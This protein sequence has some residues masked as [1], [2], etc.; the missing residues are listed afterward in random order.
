MAPPP[1]TSIVFDYRTQVIDNCEFFVGRD[2]IVTV[3]TVKE[4]TG[5]FKAYA[6]RCNDVAR[7]ALVS[8]DSFDTVQKAI[9]SLHMKSAEAVH[10]YITTNGFSMPPDLKG[11]K[12]DSDADDDAASLASSGQTASSTAAL[13]EWDSSDEEAM[14]AEG[15]ATFNGGRPRPSAR[16][17]RKPTAHG[18]KP[19]DLGDLENESDE[20][21]WMQPMRLRHGSP[22]RSASSA[23]HPPPGPP[24]WPGGPPPPRAPVMS[25]HPQHAHMQHHPPPIQF[26]GVSHPGHHYPQGG[27]AV[28]PLSH[29]SLNTN[30]LPL[31][32]PG[33]LRF[34]VPQSTSPPTAGRGPVHCRSMASLP[35]P[36][37]AAPAAA[38]SPPAPGPHANNTQHKSIAT[39]AFPHPLDS[40]RVYDVRLTIRWGHHGEQRIIESC[41]ASVRA[42]QD[43]ALAYVAAHPDSFDQQPPPNPN[44]NPNNQQHV[45]A[46]FWNEIGAVADRGAACLRASVRRA[47]FGGPD[48]KE[49]S[50]DM[51]AYRGDDLTK[52]FNVLGAG[53]IPRFEIEVE[54]V[55]FEAQGGGIGKGVGGHPGQG[56]GQGQRMMS[57]GEYPSARQ[58]AFL[59]Q[60]R[61]GG[62]GK[63]G[64][65]EKGEM[66]EM[67][68]R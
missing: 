68:A 33:T 52:L 50:Y 37:A 49:G 65:G 3:V 25:M 62:G 39:Y 21:Q 67:G 45:T 59:R 31:H 44:P 48:D 53:S 16:K 20:E 46:R 24:A 32:P 15:F 35:N 38:P 47:F 14:I 63:G 36:A 2:D 17:N 58:D 43:A 4:P 19:R 22:V 41:R 9:E 26:A 57:L 13:S 60:G 11:A 10:Q 64:K 42:L 1:S 34:N 56:Q 6:I 40:T 51:S 66:G 8:S 55:G 18:K 12:L 30:M 54:F 28:S 61:G 29:P 23:N 7:D 5:D 27:P